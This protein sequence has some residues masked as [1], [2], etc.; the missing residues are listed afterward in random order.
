MKFMTTQFKHKKYTRKM[1]T[2]VSNR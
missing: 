2:S 1:R